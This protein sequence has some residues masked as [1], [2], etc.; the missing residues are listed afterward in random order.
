MPLIIS[1]KN[2]KEFDFVNDHGN[3]HYS[4]YFMLI[5]A[6][7]NTPSFTKQNTLSP[8]YGIK[9]GRRYS[10]KATVRNKVKRRIRHICTL[11]TQGNLLGRNKSFI[12]IPKRNFDNVEFDILMSAFKSICKKI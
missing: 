9:V 6:D 7:K 3:R 11:L 12:V 10:K 8:Q 2:Q 4:K 1:L 5:T